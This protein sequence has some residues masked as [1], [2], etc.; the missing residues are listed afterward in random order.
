MVLENN[1]WDG[2]MVLDKAWSCGMVLDN[3]AW[4]GVKVLD[5]AWS[6][7]MVLHNNAWD[8]TI[9]HNDLYLLLIFG[10]VN[11]IWPNEL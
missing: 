5:K 9:D 7:G 6:C 3:N 8:V 10:L 11:S 4:D 2:V 1:A